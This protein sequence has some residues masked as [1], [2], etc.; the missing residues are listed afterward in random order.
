MNFKNLNSYYPEDPNAT[1]H[2]AAPVSVSGIEMVNTRSPHSPMRFSFGRSSAS[3]PDLNAIRL[4]SRA[5][6]LS[7]DETQFRI[8][9][10]IRGRLVTYLTQTLDRIVNEPFA[11][12]AKRP[13]PISLHLAIE[14]ITQNELSDSI[15]IIHFADDRK[16]YKD[17]Y[18]EKP[19]LEGNTA[20]MAEEIKPD[21]NDVMKPVYATNERE[22][23]ESSADE[24]LKIDTTESAKGEDASDGMFS[25][26][27]R[28]I[29][30][31]ENYQK[32]E[33]E[34]DYSVMQGS[35][36]ENYEEI[37]LQRITNGQGVNDPRMGSI[38]GFSGS[39]PLESKQLVDYV[40][41]LDT[42]YTYVSSFYCSFSLQF[43]M[44]FR[45][46]CR[47]KKIHSVIVRGAYYCPSAVRAITEHLKISLNST[48]M[49][50]PDTVFKFP[51]AKISGCRLV[52]QDASPAVRRKVIARLSEVVKNMS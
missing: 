32:V 3:S 2:A 39:L 8:D 43:Q 35:S 17:L 27:E 31:Y 51:F 19:A 12:F 33:M 20:A 34:Y 29:A 13:D 36:Q 25:R 11:Y 40:A 37:L 46:F 10:P 14:Y 44:Y 18:R 15:Y 6:R 21:D 16:L 38:D 5:H 22:Q 26:A 24:P 1:S 50:V 48:I 47:F 28:R 9:Y 4:P 45:V 41:I 7:F 23:I 49:G 52:V 30:N 42:F